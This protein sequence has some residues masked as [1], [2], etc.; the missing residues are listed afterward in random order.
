[1]KYHDSRL[2]LAV[3]FIIL[4]ITATIARAVDQRKATT[5]EILITEIVSDTELYAVAPCVCQDGETCFVINALDPRSLISGDYYIIVF[6]GTGRWYSPRTIVKI[7]GHRP[8]INP[9]PPIPAI[10]ACAPPHPPGGIFI[11]PNIFL[12]PFQFPCR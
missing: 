9:P 10:E 3:V 2:V 4:A 1:M 8:T 5:T 6:R 12:I 7:V 11:S